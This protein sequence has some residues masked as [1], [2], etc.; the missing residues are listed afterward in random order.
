MFNTYV[1]VTTADRERTPCECGCAG[2]L[3]RIRAE[4]DAL[5]AAVE[6][7]TAGVAEQ[8]SPRPAGS[9]P[10][11]GARGLAAERV[12]LFRSLFVGREDVYAQR[13]EKDGR[14]GWYPQLERLPGQTW[15]EAKDARRYRQLTDAAIHDHLSGK[16]TVGLYPMLADD[17]CRLLA[18][19]FDGEQWQLDA[20]AY[21]QAADAA[22]VP[23]VVEVSRSGQGAH[24]WI[25]S[26]SR[27]RRWTRERW[28][29]G[30]CGRRW[31]SAAS[32]GWTATT[33]SSRPRTTCR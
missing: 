18:C 9:S 22:G 24:A 20:Q 27:C 28:G 23:T 31:R 8:A 10:A 33:G 16:A 4:L 26:A 14:K 6:R 32:W 12:A 3:A 13:W 29:S 5:R 19:D 30:C 25:F 15:Q 7:L 2:E 1:T 11:A 17:T 21:V